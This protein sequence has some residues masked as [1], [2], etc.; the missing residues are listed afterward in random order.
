MLYTR[1]E[2]V[3]TTA[4]DEYTGNTYPNCKKYIHSSLFA[5]DLLPGNR[6]YH[7]KR[8]Q[9]QVTYVQKNAL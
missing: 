2:M 1:I 5:I 8:L 9:N 7:L 3:P 4:S 6:Q